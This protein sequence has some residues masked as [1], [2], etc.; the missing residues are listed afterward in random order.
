MTSK[1]LE[2]WRAAWEQSNRSIS[3]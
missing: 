2:I 1:L 3:H